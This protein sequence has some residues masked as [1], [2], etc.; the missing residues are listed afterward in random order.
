MA[1]RDLAKEDAPIMVEIHAVELQP[2]V[3][4]RS[5]LPETLKGIF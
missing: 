1:L 3:G 5:E 2:T 4:L